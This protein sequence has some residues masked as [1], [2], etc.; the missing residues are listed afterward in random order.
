MRILYNDAEL[1][2]YLKRGD[3]PA[4]DQVYNL[5][6]KS[7]CYFA[8]KIT[9]DGASAEDI[10]TESFVKL[11][12]KNPD[13]ETL[14]HL[15]SFLYTSTR[16]A[17][18]DLLRMRKRHYQAHSAIKYL[19][20][21]SEEATEHAVIMAE[22]LQAIYSAIDLLPDKCKSVV[23][24]A[25]IDGLDNEQIANKTGMT[26]QTVRNYKSEGIKLLRISLFKNGGLSSTTLFWCL[27]YMGEK[28][29]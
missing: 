2:A 7:L 5:Y 6:F 23:K 20:E 14:Q 28:L 13:F 27:L 22:V 26:Y 24:L 16:N 4:F 9:G 19:A 29:Q 8:E 1:L 10:A 25:L 3:A 17:C 21:I 11:L 15:R 12:Q 18:I